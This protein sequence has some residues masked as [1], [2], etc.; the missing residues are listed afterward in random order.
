MKLTWDISE[1][2]DEEV[3]NPSIDDIKAFISKLTRCASFNGR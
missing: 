2:V 1:L 3:D